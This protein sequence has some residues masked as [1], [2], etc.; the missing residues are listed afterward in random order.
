MF[1]T[2][3]FRFLR[4]NKHNVLP[5]NLLLSKDD[6]EWFNDY[7]FQAILTVLKPLLLSRIELYNSGHIIKRTSKAPVPFPLNNSADQD[8]GLEDAGVILGGSGDTNVIQDNVSSSSIDNNSRSSRRRRGNPLDRP[9]FC[10]RF[11]FRASTASERGGAVLVTDKSLGFSRV[12]KEVIEGD[13]CVQ[14]GR[15]ISMELATLEGEKPM[16]DD[17][18]GEGIVIREEDESDSLRVSDFKAGT[19]KDGDN[20]NTNGDNNTGDDDDYQFQAS[21]SQP[22]GNKRELSTRA[23][24]NGKRAK[25]DDLD[26]QSSQVDQKPTLQVNYSSLA[27]HPQTLYIIV[28]SLGF[29]TATIPASSILPFTSTVEGKTSMPS[30]GSSGGGTGGD[31][32]AGNASSRVSDPQ[33]LED[34]EESLFPPG[35]DDLSSL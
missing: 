9:Q 3:N 31:S 32:G 12:K 5:L 27:I 11:G 14:K 8:D 26:A 29:S 18:I 16:Q 35:M 4:I 28:R 13:E 33:D 15:R 2:T 22:R 6:L 20:D 34:D 17:I 19:A 24:R 21:A 30:G 25:A 23:K 1:T 7:S 10:I